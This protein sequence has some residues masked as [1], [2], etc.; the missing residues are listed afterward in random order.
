MSFMTSLSDWFKPRKNRRARLAARRAGFGQVWARVLGR[1]RVRAHF[2]L[3]QFEPRV[4]LSAVVT[5]DKQAYAPTDTVNVTGSGFGASETIDLQIVNETT[6]V[7]YTP[8]TTADDASGGFSST[9]TVP[10]DSPGDTFQVTATGETSASSAQATFAGLTTWVYTLPTDYHPGQTANVFAGGFQVGEAVDF[11]ITNLTDGN[12]YSPWSVTDGSSSDLD[13]ATDG[14]I[15]TGWVVPQDALNSTLEVTATGEASGLTAQNTFTDAAAVDTDISPNF[16]AAGTSTTFSVL[17]ENTTTDTTAP[18]KTIQVTVPAGYSNVSVASTAATAGTGTWTT[19]VTGNNTTGPETVTA[20]SSGSGLGSVRTTLTG[21]NITATQTAITVASGTGVNNGDV[22]L[23]QNEQLQVTAGGGTTSLT[24]TRGYKN[25]TAATHNSGTQ[26]NRDEWLRLNITATTPTTPNGTAWSVSTFSSSPT[27]TTLNG[28]VTAGQTKMTVASASGIANNDVLLINSEQVQVTNAVTTTLNGA[29]TNSQTTITVA[30]VTGIN[31]NDVLLIDSEQMQVNENNTGSK[32]LTVSRGFSGTTAV[33]HANM[34]QVIDNTLTVA[35]GFNG[36]TAAAHANGAQVID[37]NIPGAASATQTLGMDIEPIT[38]LTSAINA[39]QTTINVA[40]TAGFSNNELILID[41]EQM[42]VMNPITATTLTVQRAQGGTTAASH[43]SGA[44]ATGVGDNMGVP[45][46]RFYTAAFLSS[47]STTLSSAINN[48][49]L[50]ANVNNTQTTLTVPS[51]SGIANNDVIQIDSEQLKVTAQSTTGG[52]TTLTVTRGV[53]GTTAVN[54]N[55]GAQVGETTITVASGVGIP[56]GALLY[57]DSEDMQVTAGGGTTSLSV[58]RGA[59]GTTAASHSNGAQVVNT[60][61]TTLSAPITTT[62]QTTIGVTSGAGIANGAVLVIESEEMLVTAGGGTTTLTVTRGVNTT[63]AASHVSASRVSKT[64]TPVVGSGSTTYA[65]EIIDTTGNADQIKSATVA[66][67]IDFTGL[68]S[69]SSTFTVDQF[70]STVRGT[71][72]LSVED[73][74]IRLDSTPAPAV[75][76]NPN[77]YLT[78]VFSATAG[79][80]TGNLQ[81]YTSA[82]KDNTTGSDQVFPLVGGA[83][84]AT[85]LVN[86]TPVVTATPVSATEGTQFS[87]QVATFTDSD[88]TQTHTATINW[89][90][91]TTSVGTVTESNGSGTVSGTHTYVGDTLNGG[92]G[93]SEGTTTMTVTVT[94]SSGA[95]NSSGSG[96]ATNTVSD[97]NVAATGGSTFNITEGSATLTNVTVAT[98]TDP[99]NPSPGNFEDASDY[100]ASI[101]WGDGTSSAGTITNNNNGTWTVTGS[102]T[103]SGDNIGGVNSGVSEGAATISATVSHDATTA[104]VVTDTAN[105]S[106]PN[107]VAAGVSAFSLTEGSATL[108]NATVATFT[109]PGNPSPGNFEDASDYSAS[110]NWGDGSAA[111][112]GTITNNANGTWTVTG[113]HTY[114][115]DNIGGTGSGLSEGAATISVTISHDATTP[116]MVTDTAN[117][118]D[119]NVVATGVSAFSLT[120]G[121]ATLT[122]ATVATFTDPGNPSPGNFE[123]ASDYSAS[124]NWGDGSAASTGT[125][126]NNANGTWTVTGSHT[127]SG[128]NIG[129]TGSG[130][131]E[132]AATITVTISHDATTPQVVT[133]T[134]NISDPNVAAAG[135]SAFSLTEGSATL[136]NATVATFTDPGNPSPGNL[137]DAAD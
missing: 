107:V 48:T 65:M 89:G 95:N 80:T 137:E 86:A 32:T 68:T 47:N 94:D 131:S 18:Y 34:A 115:G 10:S 62:T 105:I 63:T 59:N 121:S 26:V 6:G 4:L 37:G 83:G 88:T 116:Q 38:T 43:A 19:F 42:K 124:I 14:H 119:P 103:Y 41:S 33:T 100:S 49:T 79:T 28:S 123:D 102:H 27:I 91:A 67:P 25:T 36:T 61:V 134:A 1:P 128:D 129:G 11:Q 117:I 20:Y 24:V 12:V 53:N 113:S 90:D 81:F 77:D 21:P 118:S 135:V 39:T 96:T 60:T 120:E 104:Q 9:W 73:N 130:V 35:R 45:P 87:G 114:S 71:M 52:T 5:T 23:I 122:N 70:N 29:I 126:T 74:F 2:R 75:P 8:W 84:Q 72:D 112:T 108:T 106:D 57:I 93:E 58:T 133:D 76:I 132:G 46:N 101:A 17:V 136:T 69:N 78:F 110:I 92:T 66:A 40:S 16:A 98:F 30:S 125:I 97:P 85:V 31:T 3:E 7:S 82:W 44:Q 54:H 56:N 22:L 15:Q 127:Y 50:S 111:S 55:S 99:G 64:T 51:G 109:D 13:G